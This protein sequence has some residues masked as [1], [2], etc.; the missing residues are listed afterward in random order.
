MF[1]KGFCCYLHLLLIVGH[2]VIFSICECYLLF[3]LLSSVHAPTFLA[4]IAV[5]LGTLSIQEFKLLYFGAYGQGL[6]MQPVR[7]Q[8]QTTKE[9]VFLVSTCSLWFSVTENEHKV[10]M[11][12]MISLPSKFLIR[13][14]EV[15]WDSEKKIHRDSF[16]EKLE[17]R[18]RLSKLEK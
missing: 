1:S 6:N 16:R 13:E 7:I 10:L 15:C 17:E 9:Y 8:I 5:F 18:N 2:W 12:C 14:T 3:L 11:G 4:C